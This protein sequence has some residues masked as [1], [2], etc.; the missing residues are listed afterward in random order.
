MKLSGVSW[1][2]ILLSIQH[3]DCLLSGFKEFKTLPRGTPAAVER[4]HLGVSEFS[5]TVSRITLHSLGAS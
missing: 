2:L 1:G 4:F 5:G 3:S